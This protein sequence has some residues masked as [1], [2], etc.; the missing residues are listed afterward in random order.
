MRG[1]DLAELCQRFYVALTHL[2]G[3]AISG[4]TLFAGL[5]ADAI[6]KKDESP[7]SGEAGTL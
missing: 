7:D 1:L 5:A 2:Q 3:A 4:Q 6:Y